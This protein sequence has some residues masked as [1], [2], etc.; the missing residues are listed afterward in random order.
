ME[1][2]ISFVIREGQHGTA[3]SIYLPYGTRTLRFAVTNGADK[4]QKL[5][6]RPNNI[7]ANYRETGLIRG[8]VDG[9]AT[10]SDTWVHWAGGDEV[11]AC[12]KM[13]E[14]DP[15][16]DKTV[17]VWEVKPV[18]VDPGETRTVFM[19]VTHL[20]GEVKPL[21]MT[22]NAVTMEQD[23]EKV[24][25]SS[26][27]LKLA[28]PTANGSAVTDPLKGTWNEAGTRLDFSG[29]QL[30]NYV[31][32]WWAPEAYAYIDAGDLP[33]RFKL[34]MKDE[35]LVMKLDADSSGNGGTTI[36]E[37]KDHDWE[38]GM[39]I[40][41][42]RPSL[43]ELFHF[44]GNRYYAI[45]FWF[46]WLELNVGAKHEVPDAERIDVL[47]DL[48]DERV[49]YMGTDF[50][51]K[52]TWGRLSRGEKVGKAEL[53]LGLSSVDDFAVASLRS[54]FVKSK[55]E[56]PPK[57]I[58]RQLCEAFTFQTGPQAHVPTLSNVSLFRNITSP[59]VR[60]G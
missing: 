37:I 35:M 16:E 23:K 46:A 9:D 34:F 13:A 11:G 20:A 49:R 38:P 45:R 52:E 57:V 53:G 4:P 59:D 19:N 10:G 32:R 24:L 39:E 36:A 56:N 18:D 47:F 12:V 6:L 29:S 1:Q 51:Y 5:W 50:H 3:E 54:F 44:C 25:D 14:K 27:R 40:H 55:Q 15:L 58:A 43:P 41:R 26:L 48:K 7:P 31:P 42:V 8:H 33:G 2:A 30:A 21:E 60:E 17:K 22:V 28:L